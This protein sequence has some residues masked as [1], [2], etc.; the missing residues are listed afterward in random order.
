MEFKLDW[1]KNAKKK[2][3]LFIIETMHRVLDSLMPYFYGV[4]ILYLVQNPHPIF[5]FKTVSH[6][7]F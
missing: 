5:S 2:N 1:E 4:H 6:I 3:Q 7:Q